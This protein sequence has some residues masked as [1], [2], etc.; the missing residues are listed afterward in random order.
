VS[1]GTLTVQ[2]PN[3]DIKTLVMQNRRYETAQVSSQPASIQAN[4]LIYNDLSTND[5]PGL[6]EFRHFDTRSLRLNSD[7]VLHIYRDTANTV[8]LLTDPTL[9]HPEYVFYFDNNGKFFP[10]NQDGSDP[11]ID[12]DYAYMYFS[13][14][15]PFPDNSGTPYIVG[16]FNNFRLDENSR[17]YFD[18]SRRLY[19]RRLLLKQGVYDYQYVWVPNGSDKPDLS[20]IEGNHFE[21]ENEY[22]LLVYYH[23]VGARWTELVGFRTLSTNTNR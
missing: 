3:E 22:Q 11:R 1:Y 16:Q 2:N 4:R 18:P 15:T 20:A 17:L 10:G 19:G 21:T 23:P 9:N 7:R 14:S 8:V 5:F 13:L 6:N 12:A